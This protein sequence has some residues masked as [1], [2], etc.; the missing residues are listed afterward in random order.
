[1]V[2]RHAATIDHEE[3]HVAV[4]PHEPARE[5]LLDQRAAD[6]LQLAR[7]DALVGALQELRVRLGERLASLGAGEDGE[8]VLV[9]HAPMLPD[10]ARR[11]KCDA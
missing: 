4:L 5:R 11:L 6:V 9:D 8:E 1:M 10:R 2:L 7:G 3:Q